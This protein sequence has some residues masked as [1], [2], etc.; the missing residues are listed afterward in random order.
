MLRLISILCS[1]IL[2][3]PSS[4]FQPGPDSS[5]KY[6]ISSPASSLSLALIPYGASVTNLLY[7]D[8]DLVAG[9]DNASTYAADPTHPHLGGIVGRYANRIR[10]SSFTMPECPVDGEYGVCQD[11]IYRVVPNENPTEEHPDGID[12]LHGGPDGWDYRMWSVLEHKAGSIKFGL[13]DPDGAMGFPG[14]VVAEVVYTVSEPGIWAFRIVA[15]PTTKDA[16]TPIML[17][18]HVYWN[19]D[20]FQV[21]DNHSNH[22]GRYSDDGESTVLSGT[23]REH[24]LWMPDAK[25]RIAVDS[26]LIPTGEILDN[27][28][29]DANDFWSRPRS[30]GEGIDSAGAVGNCGAGCTGYGKPFY[31]SLAL[32]L[33]LSLLL[34]LSLSLPPL[35]TFTFTV[36]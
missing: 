5:G 10:N 32:S 22:K 34:S 16:K 1:L 31:L 20:G 26:I 7:A 19:L 25:R 9:Y 12:T 27:T 21:V 35:G 17:S 2:I 11:A 30:F 23:I 14:E 3:L 4:A 6:W 28:K 18:S 13:V 33:A 29:E 15:R 36:I 24:T 8:L